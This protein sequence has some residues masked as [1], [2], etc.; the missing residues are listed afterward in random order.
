MTTDGEEHV[1]VARRRLVVARR[2][3]RHAMVIAGGI[4]LVLGAAGGTA[5]GYFSVTGSGSGAASVGSIQPV[6]VEHL[7]ATV[8]DKLRPGGAATLRLKIVNANDVT[9][10][11]I[12]V[13]AG[14]SPTVTAT[15]GH[16]SCTAADDGVSVVT[17]PNLHEVLSP[18][19]NI[20]T[21]PTAVEM[22]PSA[23]TACQGANFSVPVTI[24]VKK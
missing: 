11:L 8:T 21:L 5:Y 14:P 9:V 20:V 12:S 23:A 1:P 7:T 3:H 22:S 24:T 2:L 13:Q 4:A 10:V 6:T 17:R 18:G 15:A 19:A 16:P